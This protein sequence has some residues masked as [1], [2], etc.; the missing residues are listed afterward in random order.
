MRDERLKWA[1]EWGW[2]HRRNN[3]NGQVTQMWARANVCTCAHTTHTAFPV[4][5]YYAGHILTKQSSEKKT[6]L[7]ILKCSINIHNGLQA[8]C[9]FILPS[10][11]FPLWLLFSAKKKILD[12]ADKISMVQVLVGDAWKNKITSLWEQS[13][14]SFQ[15]QNILN[16]L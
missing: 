14:T 10:S 5:R 7:I 6:W 1:W 16:I 12:W 9:W 2:K 3:A 4:L 8:G 13:H 11:L 15:F